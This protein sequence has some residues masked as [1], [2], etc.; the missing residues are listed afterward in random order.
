MSVSLERKGETC[1]VQADR[2]QHLTAFS[3]AFFT[4]RVELGI[5]IKISDFMCV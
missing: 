5:S 4:Y 1:Y 2:C 3:S